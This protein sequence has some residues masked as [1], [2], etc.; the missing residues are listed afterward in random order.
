MLMTDAALQSER[1]HRGLVRDDRLVEA[2]R[3]AQ[4]SR[5]GGVVDEVV[6]L[7]RLLDQ[8]QVEA[9]Q[10]GERL[11]V[12]QRV[13]RVGVD[14]QRDRSERIAH[15]GGVGDVATGLDL[16]L[17]PHVSLV[18][19]A[20]R[21]PRRAPRGRA[22][23]RRH[24]RRHPVVHGA[25]VLPQR[26][27][28]A[29]QRRVEHRELQA[30]LGH[31]VAR[32]TVRARLRPSSGDS[33]WRSSR[34][35]T[36]QRAAT[37]QAPCVYSL[38]YSGAAPV[39]I[40]PQPSPSVVRA[41]DEDDLADGLGAERRRERRRPAG[42]A[43]RAARNPR[44]STDAAGRAMGMR[45]GYAGAVTRTAKRRSRPGAADA[46]REATATAAGTAPPGRRS[47]RSRR[48]AP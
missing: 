43:A 30:G 12:R 7:E 46:A 22:G 25:E 48:S 37:S 8:Q 47:R 2:H 4:A 45:S 44:G 42:S 9:V 40:S 14:L 41:R 29:A 24:A 6:L 19:I 31:A 18:E 17:D 3:G 1:V 20:S 10:L 38:E 15:R 33:V 39:T 16:D 13:C 34:A 28:L 11:G 21:R 32:R 26:S 35:G 23:C 5:K 36:S 27:A